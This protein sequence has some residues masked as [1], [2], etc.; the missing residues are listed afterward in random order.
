MDTIDR[1]G[2]EGLAPNH[3]PRSDVHRPRPTPALFDRRLHRFARLP[4]GARLV[5][6]SAKLVMSANELLRCYRDPANS[7]AEVGR[8]EAELCWKRERS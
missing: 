8:P 7:R 4:S 6:E 5:T 2:I 3:C 1:D